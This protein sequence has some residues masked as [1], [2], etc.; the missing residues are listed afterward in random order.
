MNVFV[1]RRLP[2]GALDR[3]AAAHEVEVWSEPT[4]LPRAELLARAAAA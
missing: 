4:P 2:G 3:L 1:T